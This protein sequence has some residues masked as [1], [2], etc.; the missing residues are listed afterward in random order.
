MEVP[1]KLKIELSYVLAILLLSIYPK[2]PQNT[3]SKKYMHPN[4]LRSIFYNS[5]DV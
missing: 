4:I 1:K 3:S 2:I 5:Q